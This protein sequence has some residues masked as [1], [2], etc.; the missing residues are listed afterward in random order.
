MGH[1]SHNFI[2][3]CVP[4]L[5]R[6]VERGMVSLS[7]RVC[8]KLNLRLALHEKPEIRET[9]EF[10]RGSTDAKSLGALP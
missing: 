1:Q 6:I 2:V 3:V 10:K 7:R 9:T 5:D 8:K 4:L